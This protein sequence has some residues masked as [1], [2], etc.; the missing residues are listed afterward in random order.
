MTGPLI[1]SRNFLSM[2]P[3]SSHHYDLYWL[4]YSPV[5][6]GRRIVPH[7]IE[8]HHESRR[9]KYEC[10]C[11]LWSPDCPVWAKYYTV[12]DE[13]LGQLTYASCNTCGL[14]GK[15]LLTLVASNT[16]GF[17]PFS[18]LQPVKSRSILHLWSYSNTSD[19]SYSLLR[20]LSGFLSSLRSGYLLISFV[21]FPFI[22]ACSF[23]SNTSCSHA[24][25]NHVVPFSSCSRIMCWLN[26]MFV[27]SLPLLFSDICFCSGPLFLTFLYINPPYL[28]I[29]TNLIIVFNLVSLHFRFIST[30][31]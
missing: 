25:D 7:R 13:L 23:L 24:T 5:F 15:H 6:N 4:R 19:I 16:Y 31:D 12:D 28:S 27:R 30:S 17:S 8:V 14:H 9:Q 1:L 3:R 29:Q 10:W 21:L 2:S 22:P 20:S 26:L 11:G 18:V